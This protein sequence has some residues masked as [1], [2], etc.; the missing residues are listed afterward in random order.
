MKSTE[1]EFET[2]IGLE[3]HIQLA[4][5]EKIF[6]TDRIA[7]GAEPNTDISPV[8]LAYPGTLPRLNRKLIPKAIRLGLALGSTIEPYSRFDRKNYFYADLPK[9]YQ[10]T[11]DQF[12]ICTGG[13]FRLSNRNIRIHHLHLE[14]DAGKSIHDQDP[15]DT[16]I[17]L[18]RAGTPLVELVTEPDFRSG[19]EVVEFMEGLRQLVRWLEVSDGNMEEGSMRCDI[20]VSIRPVGDAKLGA[21]CEVKNVNSMR[22]AKRAIL[23]ETNRQI[24]LIKQGEKIVQETRGFDAGT[25]TTYSLRE[26]EEAHDYR[27]FP[28][29]DL[30]PL[31]LLVEEI[32]AQKKQLPE[33]PWEQAKRFEKIYE[34]PA[35]EAG[36][37]V[38]EKDTAAYFER[39]AEMAESNSIIREISKLIIN[40]LR[41]M[42][43]SENRAVHENNVPGKN[44]IKFV[45]L[46]DN[47]SITSSVAYQF[48]L[49]DLLATPDADPEELARKLDL[50]KDENGDELE[51][52][53]R[54]I[55]DEN[56]TKAEAYRKGKK[57]L[58]GFFMGAVMRQTNGKADPTESERI[59]RE[60]LDAE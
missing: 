13:Q 36:Q 54:K 20:N 29:P 23:H 53:I 52:L 43:A 31:I 10:I 56:Q 35:F 51:A 16:L 32:E 60:F 48:L 11:Q 46:I 50:L 39:L 45:K 41:P 58:I 1:L 25:G 30:P 26:K 42:L 44:W 3:V 40:R 7:F 15:E 17:D 22:F 28:E 2:V 59:F 49:P 38:Q 24:A 34:L 6:C 37:L 57:G 21:R 9:G 18:N 19:E 4:T 14:E 33:L 27:Y 55:L 5:E 12:P 8:S 47:Q